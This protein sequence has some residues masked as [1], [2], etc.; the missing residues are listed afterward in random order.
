[1][2]TTQQP[3][4]RIGEAADGAPPRLAEG[5]ELIGEYEDSG[6]KEPPSIA[7]RADGQV[8]Q[9]PRILFLIAEHADGARGYEEIAEHVS[10]GSGRG[11]SDENVRFLVEERLRPLGV[12]AQADGSSPEAPKADPL[13]AL[14][15]RVAVVPEGVTRAITT[16][17]Y[18]FFFPPVAAAALAGLVG[19]DVWLFFFHGIAQSVRELVYNPLLLLMVFGLI[20]FATALHEVGH[21]TAARYGGAKPGV[22]GAGIYVVWPAFYTDVTDAYRLNRVG[23]L[24]TDLGGVYFNALFTLGLAGAYFLTG[25]EPLL[26]VALIQHFQIFQQLLPLLRLDGYYILSDLTGVPDLFARIGPTLKSAIPWR[27]TDDR[28]RELKPWVRATVTA[29]VVVLVPF[30]A[31]VFGAMIFNA[32]RI[33][34]T[35][36]DSLYVHLDQADTAFG[37]GQTASGLVATLQMGALALPV[38]GAGYSGSRV[39]GRAIRGGWRWSEGSTVRRMGVVTGTAAAIACLGFVWWPNGDYKPLQPGER[40]TVQGLAGQWGSVKTGRPGI[41]PARE[42]GLGGAGFVHKQGPGGDGSHVPS[43]AQTGTGVSETSETS[44]GGTFSGTNSTS[45]TKATSTAATSTTTESTTSTTATE[46]TTTTETT[47]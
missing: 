6:Y 3:D 18:P 16:V 27:K 24:R 38:L 47:P 22:M 23:R 13:L 4:R 26:V 36:W 1:M 39:G 40:G 8:I 7:R 5:I 11:V 41:S 32:P 29:W 20:V 44:S 12:L 42:R 19:F 43:P 34:A 9:L 37:S 46:T 10:E 15:F 33:L 14:K 25:F 21:A 30:L 45:G 35:A 28:V 17:F 31:F 2:T